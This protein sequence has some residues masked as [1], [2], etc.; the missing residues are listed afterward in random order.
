MPQVQPEDRRADVDVRQVSEQRG[1]PGAHHA[2]LEQ[3]GGGGG[4]RLPLL[5]APLTTSLPG[6]ATLLALQ[7]LCST[8]LLARLC[9]CMPCGG[10]AKKYMRGLLGVRQS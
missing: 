5:P 6:Q 7:L 9:C 4:A 1:E 2:S 8:T 3:A 10:R